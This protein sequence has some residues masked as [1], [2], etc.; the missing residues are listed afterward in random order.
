MSRQWEWWSF[1]DFR[2]NFS[3]KGL[4]HN[5]TGL[6]SIAVHSLFRVMPLVWVYVQFVLLFLCFLLLHWKSVLRNEQR[7]SLKR[8]ITGGFRLPA[9]FILAVFIFAMGWDYA[10][11][12]MVTV[13]GLLSVP[14]TIHERMWGSSGISLTSSKISIAWNFTSKTLIRLHDMV[15]G[16]RD[17]FTSLNY[18]N[19]CGTALTDRRSD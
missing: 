18:I 2:Q 9:L 15:L 6:V 8:M 13:T 4:L 5:T 12:E 17:K 7:R 10:V 11:V 1:N 19:G 3:C 14:H 16:H